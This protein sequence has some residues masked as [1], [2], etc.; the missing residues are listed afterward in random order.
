MKQQVPQSETSLPVIKQLKHSLYT[1]YAAMLLGF[2][3]EAINDPAAAERYLIE[4][5][6]D[7]QPSDIEHITAPGANPFCRLQLFTRKKLAY[8]HGTDGFKSNGKPGVATTLTGNKLVNMMS[9]EQQHVF[10]GV[11]YQG[12]SISALATELNMPVATVRQLFKDSITLIRNK[13]L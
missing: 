5:F 7:L 12:K 13:P 6:N 9:T 4:V 10:C 8:I 3:Q 2:L 1:N 11:Y